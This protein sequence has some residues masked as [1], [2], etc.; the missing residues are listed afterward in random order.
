MAMVVAAG[1]VG[2]SDAD[3]VMRQRHGI[4]LSLALTWIAAMVGCAF[5][6]E[7]RRLQLWLRT[8]P[9]DE[10]FGI[11]VARNLAIV[12]CCVGANLVAVALLSFAVVCMAT[13]D[14]GIVM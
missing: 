5:L 2:A 9:G 10:G 14:A 4:V 8:R 6:V 12:L 13:I 1:F 3:I 11:L 7:A